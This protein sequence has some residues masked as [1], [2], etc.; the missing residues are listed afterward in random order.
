M[1]GLSSVRIHADWCNIDKVSAVVIDGVTVG[2]PACAVHNCH[3]PLNSQR[4]R[5]C[6]DH[7]HL[8]H[9]CAVTDCTAPVFPG[10]KVCNEATH[11]KV[12]VIPFNSHVASV[13]TILLSKAEGFITFKGKSMFQL[14]GRLERPRM[15]NA[16]DTVPNTSDFE[17]WEET[18]EIGP[19]GEVVSNVGANIE[20]CPDKPESGNKKIKIV[21]SRGR[22][23]NEQI[24]VCP[25]GVI[26]ARTTFFGAEAL[27]AVAVSTFQD[28]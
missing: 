8:V 3:I 20:S 27:T 12:R 19:D 24:I 25:C 4:D 14:H 26:I 15:A 5:F 10:H 17:A 16:G 22:T 18:V 1:F 11:L 21:L 28:L 9:Q 6:P 23:H 13:D 7:A 2:R